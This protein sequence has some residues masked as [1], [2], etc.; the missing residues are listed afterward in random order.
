V[1]RS[2]L[3]KVG[4]NRVSLGICFAKPNLEAEGLLDEAEI[5]AATMTTR[6]DDTSFADQANF[7]SLV[8]LWSLHSSGG[9]LIHPTSG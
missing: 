4:Q 8:G 1:S 3:S 7:F 2:C 5:V 9:G 6:K